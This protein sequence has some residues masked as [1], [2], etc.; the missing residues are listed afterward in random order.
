MAT[1]KDRL[2]G[3]GDD[4]R[5]TRFE[6]MS[7]LSVVLLC[8]TMAAL[9]F[10]Q[11]PTTLDQMIAAGKSQRELA[12]YLFDTHGCRTCHTIGSEGKLGFTKLGE[13]RAQGF[14]GCISTL[15][16]MSVIAKVP[17]TQRSAT[18]RRR[19]ERFEEFG[20]ATCHKLTP[21]KMGLTEEGAKL[22]HLHLGCVEVE[23]LISAGSGSQ[24]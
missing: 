22:A 15:K 16:A 21:G 14:E 3:S 9:A 19:A 13:E 20:C 11:S 1:M 17:E 7:H 8:G 18:Q 2:G 12:Q 10:A 5:R 23:K 4:R 24:P 6:N